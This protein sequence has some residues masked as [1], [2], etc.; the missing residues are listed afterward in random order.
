[1]NAAAAL[2]IASLGTYA[3]RQFSVRAL[4]NRQLPPA[5]GTTLRH[6]ALAVMAALVMSSIHPTGQGGLPAASA[7]VGLAA[8][9]IIARR[10]ENVAAA[11]AIGIATYVTAAEITG[12]LAPLG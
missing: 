8:A 6:A 5:V 1:M 10:S 7:L 3:L 11:I 2:L 12:A 4:A 9:G